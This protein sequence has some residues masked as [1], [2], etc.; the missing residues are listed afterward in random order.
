M[1]ERTFTPAEPMPCGNTSAG[2]E[3]IRQLRADPGTVTLRYGHPEH[4]PKLDIDYAIEFD[5][6]DDPIV[7][8]EEV[9]Q[10]GV[11]LNW[12]LETEGLEL[13]YGK[14]GGKKTRYPAFEALAYMVED[15]LEKDA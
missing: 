5:G 15:E 2:E 6:T 10:D 7:K 8:V 3:P 14:S 13:L 4:G 1:F 12:L 11:V 9:R